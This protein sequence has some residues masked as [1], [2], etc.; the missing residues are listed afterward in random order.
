MIMNIDFFLTIFPFLPPSPLCVS[1]CLGK[2][3]GLRVVARSLALSD[4]RVC[5]C[6][7]VCVTL[8]SG[9][10]RVHNFFLST[11]IRFTRNIIVVTLFF[12]EYDD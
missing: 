5:A 4:K 3:K 1:W 11:Q 9:Y 8:G 7:S 2:W 10:S 6:V 12:A